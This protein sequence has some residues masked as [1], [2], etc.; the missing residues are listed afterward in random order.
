M[1]RSC[2]I[3][4]IN[5]LSAPQKDVDARLAAS[6]FAHLLWPQ[7]K[8]NVRVFGKKKMGLFSSQAKTIWG[9]FFVIFSTI[10]S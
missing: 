6:V 9:L 7:A 3:F 8:K 5:Q 2:T 10:S 1:L 4:L